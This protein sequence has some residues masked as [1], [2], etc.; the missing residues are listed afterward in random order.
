VIISAQGINPLVFEVEI[1]CAFV[2]KDMISKR[3]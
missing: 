2:I 1:Q 3:I